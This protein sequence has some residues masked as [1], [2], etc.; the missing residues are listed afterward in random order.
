MENNNFIL[1]PY[2][3]V[4]DFV[5]N[6]K[7]SCSMIDHRDKARLLTYAPDL[8]SVKTLGFKLKDEY[9][10]ADLNT[11]EWSPENLIHEIIAD[12]DFAIEKAED[13]RGISSSLMHEVLVM[14]NF[15][16]NTGIEAQPN[17]NDYGLDYAKKTKIAFKNIEEQNGKK[18]T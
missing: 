15:A 12:A 7:G 16:F 4:V 14:W 8:E 3:E 13:K 5:I 9:A 6:K 1:R 10:F 2:K 18:E 17:Y 11:K